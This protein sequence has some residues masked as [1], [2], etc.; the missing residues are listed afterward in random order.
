MLGNLGCTAPHRQ[1]PDVL[2]GSGLAGPAPRHG[3]CYS[4]FQVS[5][6]GERGLRCEQCG[7]RFNRVRWRAGDGEP[8]TQSGL[9]L[10]LWLRPWSPL[11]HRHFRGNYRAF[12][13]GGWACMRSMIDSWSAPSMVGQF[14]SN[15]GTFVDPKEF[16]INTVT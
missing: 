11:W 7:G 5:R 14:A 13:S 10:S 12:C 2:L 15:E 4:A 8:L 16:T 6:V 3:K 9:L 1:P